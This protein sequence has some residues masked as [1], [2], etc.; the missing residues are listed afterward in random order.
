MLKSTTVFIMLIVSM[1]LI[2]GCSSG[3]APTAP[4][5][6]NQYSDLPSN[7]VENRHFLGAWTLDFDVDSL[8]TEIA[9]KRDAEFHL[10]VTTALPPPGVDI[11][12]YDPIVNVM[13]IDVTIANPY[14]YNGYNL[15]LIIYSNDRGIRLVNP[16]NWTALWD[17]PE[18]AEINPFRAFAKDEVNRLFARY[19]NHTERIQLEF[20]AGIA[21]VAI[22]IDASWP[23]NCGEPYMIEN[24]TQET[25]YS[26]VD[27]WSEVTIDVFDYQWDI[28]DVELC[29]PAILGD[30]SVFL[31]GITSLPYSVQPYRWGGT[32]ANNTGAGE[33]RYQGYI[34][35]TSDTSGELALYELVDIAVKH[36]TA[37][38]HD[39]FLASTI[40]LGSNANDVE[41]DDGYVYV[42]TDD[43]LSV[44]DA[45]DPAEPLWVGF[46][47]TPLKAL[48]VVFEDDMAYV[49]TGIY[50]GSNANQSFVQAFDMGDPTAPIPVWGIQTHYPYALD[51]V[52]DYLYV[53]DGQAGLKII[54]I[55]IPA[56]V[57]EIDT[58]TAK[59]VK[60][61]T[62]YACLADGT[63]SLTII[64][65]TD[66]ENPSFVSSTGGGFAVGVCIQD[67]YVYMVTSR[68]L[69]IFDVS[70]PYNP[71]TIGEK[72]LSYEL[73]GL[74]VQDDYVYIADNNRYFLVYDASNLQSPVQYS[75]LSNLDSLKVDVN[76][77]YAYLA[78][79]SNGMAIVK[80]W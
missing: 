46:V 18:G 36:G 77:R 70:N 34:K 13:D 59:D 57:G 26:V 49:A 29:C 22:A 55:T 43:G 80:L 7:T 21:P 24:F 71:I 17:I 23:G 35:S 79:E 20:P 14:A 2:A 41:Y 73:M 54:D 9:P 63:E 42:A 58:R 52:G 68:E 50:S 53:A 6:A 78:R 51:I 8:N 31:S 25:L 66:P 45:T 40:Y 56:I 32:L 38:P 74:A 12:G 62:G 72:Y 1:A 44:V 60:V 27:S 75:R 30:E 64:N 3:N 76:G 4:A 15:R 19:S 65:V 5:D 47:E 37:T 33:G 10:D 39:P 69:S 61:S 67:E 16:D 11:I 28:A 48:G